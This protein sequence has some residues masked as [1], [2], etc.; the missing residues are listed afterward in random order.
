MCGSLDMQSSPIVVTGQLIEEPNV[1]LA[2]WTKV[3]ALLYFIHALNVFIQYALSN[4]TEYQWVALLLSTFMFAFW[5]PLCGYQSSKKTGSVNL[6]LFSGVQ[7]ILGCWNMF[8]LVTLW[9][10]VTTVISVCHMCE[11]TFKA[12]NETCIVDTDSNE[13]V[14]I[15][16]ETCSKHWPSMGHIST[17]L[18][19]L[20]MTT[21]SW[22]G[23]VLAQK[24]VESKST[25]IITVG[26]IRV[27]DIYEAPVV[28]QP[29]VSTSETVVAV[30]EDSVA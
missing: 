16:E 20:A 1:K 21:V 2:K 24:T 28:V 12:G 22:V 17:T 5:L 18:L 26:S 29:S 10:F 7:G 11:P 14:N 4:A 3:I 25:H 6:K 15:A 30:P 23:A 27:P 13:T 9:M 8:S 19:L